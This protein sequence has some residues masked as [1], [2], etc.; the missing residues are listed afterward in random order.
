MTIFH[1]YVKLQE[2]KWKNVVN[3]VWEY[4]QIY[5]QHVV[6]EVKSSTSCDAIDEIELT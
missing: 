4:G 1:S 5:E 6:Y 3:R 2:D